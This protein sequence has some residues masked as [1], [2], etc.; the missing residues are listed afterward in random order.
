MAPPETSPSSPNMTRSFFATP[1]KI[2]LADCSGVCAVAGAFLSAQMAVAVVPGVAEEI[3]T[4]SSQYSVRSDYKRSSQIV[5]FR[6]YAGWD[7]IPHRPNGL[8]LKIGLRFSRFV[9]T[10][11]RKDASAHR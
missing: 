9:S 1:A 7:G 4:L 11:H 6:E 2:R 3:L 8:F 5:D 10:L